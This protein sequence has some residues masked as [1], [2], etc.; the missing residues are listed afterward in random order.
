MQ[1]ISVED[2]LPELGKEV[3]V[4]Y[5][6]RGHKGSFHVALLGV[7]GWLVS[8]QVAKNPSRITHWMPLPKPPEG[9]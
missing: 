5:K 8:S 1:W 6:S 9:N 4:Y 7:I 2:E 3:L